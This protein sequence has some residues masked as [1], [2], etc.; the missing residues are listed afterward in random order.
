MRHERAR[1][2]RSPADFDT[3]WSV[4]RSNVLEADSEQ[5]VAHVIDRHAETADQ[6][7]ATTEMADLQPNRIRRASRQHMADG[8]N[9]FRPGPDVAAED[10]ELRV[11]SRPDR[12]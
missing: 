4:G 5:F 12:G 3:P 8:I 2:R 6:S 11:E 1:V 9:Q 10:H 7:G